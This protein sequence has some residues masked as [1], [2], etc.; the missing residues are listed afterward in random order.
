MLADLK[1][2]LDK[3]VFI[4]IANAPLSL[5]FLIMT[6]NITIISYFSVQ[7]DIYKTISKSNILKK[8]KRTIICRQLV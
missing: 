2:K 6:E 5:L 3:L 7:G 1:L 4:R 8:C